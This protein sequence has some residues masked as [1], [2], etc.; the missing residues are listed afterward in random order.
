[1]TWATTAVRT[2]RGE[3]EVAA[4]TPRIVLPGMV[5]NIAAVGTATAKM[6]RDPH[7]APPASHAEMQPTRLF[8][9][10]T[11]QTRPPTAAPTLAPPLA[12]NDFHRGGRSTRLLAAPRPSS[13]G[14]S[15]K[16]RDASIKHYDAIPTCGVCRSPGLPG[17]PPPALPG[18][19]VPQRALIG[20]TSTTSGP[21]KWRALTIRPPAPL[22]ASPTSRT[23]SSLSSPLIAFVRLA[24]KP[25]DRSCRG[26]EENLFIRRKTPR[27]S[28]RCLTLDPSR[29][30]TSPS[31][32]S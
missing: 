17:C 21:S 14:I 5:T 16:G 22:V 9:T 32:R 6:A 24:G 28:T 30:S 31:R 26:R 11:L 18:Q 7:E 27:G 8:P 15:N 23:R 2:E 1:M 4:T 12:A 20:I 29:P 25:R 13:S 3:S 19:T 10:T